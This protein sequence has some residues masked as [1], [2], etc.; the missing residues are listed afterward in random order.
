MESKIEACGTTIKSV[1]ANAISHMR[2]YSHAITLRI[3]FNKVIAVVNC[4]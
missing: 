4:F 2:R 3:Y 1:E